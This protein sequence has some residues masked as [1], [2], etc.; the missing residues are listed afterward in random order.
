[1]C[2]EVEEVDQDRDLNQ[3]TPDPKKAR[4]E[5][6]AETCSYPNVLAIIVSLALTID[7]P[8]AGQGR[9]LG[10]RLRPYQYEE[11][12]AQEEEAEAELEGGARDEA[13]QIRPQDGPGDC[14][15]AKEQAA[16]QIY[17]AHLEIGCGPGE[18]VEEDHGQGDGGYDRGPLLG[19]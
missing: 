9:L 17:P 16:P 2:G 15:W 10:P 4:Y 12:D 8:A 13:N 3:G 18:G 14:G 5:S 1:M 6:D 11:G 7:Y 19:I